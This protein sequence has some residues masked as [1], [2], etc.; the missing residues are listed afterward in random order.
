MSLPLRVVTPET[1]IPFKQ[2]FISPVSEEEE[3]GLGRV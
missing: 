2:P 1:V 3:D